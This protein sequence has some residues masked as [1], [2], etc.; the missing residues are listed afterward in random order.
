MR[1]SPLEKPSEHTGIIRLVYGYQDTLRR[2]EFVKI[3]CS[4]QCNWLLH[5][6]AIR[7]RLEHYLNE[8]TL[9]LMGF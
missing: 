4:K 5:G 7:E 1:L 2:E 8:E 6:S 9:V 3:L